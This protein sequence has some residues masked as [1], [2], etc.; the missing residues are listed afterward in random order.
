MITVTGP[1]PAKG[2]SE[3]IDGADKY[4]EEQHAVLMDYH[5]FTD[6][7]SARRVMD[8]VELL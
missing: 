4:K 3:I 7:N 2:M 6:G 8:A 1:I 5:K